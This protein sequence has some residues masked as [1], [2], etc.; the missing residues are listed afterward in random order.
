VDALEQY[1]RGGLE[2]AGLPVEDFEVEIMRYID[3]VYGPE[4]QELLQADMHGIWPEHDLDP[5]RA[6][7]S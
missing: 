2:R 4:L 1:I 6:P 3:Q 7:T 5:S